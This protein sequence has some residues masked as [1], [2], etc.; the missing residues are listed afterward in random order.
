MEDFYSEVSWF[1]GTG[2]R[3]IF[4]YIYFSKNSSELIVIFKMIKK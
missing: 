4:I 1:K 3:S 2:S